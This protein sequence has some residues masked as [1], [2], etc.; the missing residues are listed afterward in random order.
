[1]RMVLSLTAAALCL[2]LPGCALIEQYRAEQEARRLA[3]YQQKVDDHEEVRVACEQPFERPEIAVLRQKIPP[4][5]QQP[6]IVQ[7]ADKTR[8]N[9]RQKAA[10]KALDELLQDCRIKQGWLENRYSSV[11][12]PAHVAGAERS[13]ALLSELWAGKLTFGQYNKGRQEIVALYE[14]ESVELRQQLQIVAAQERAAEAAEATRRA[15]ESAERAAWAERR[16]V[17]K[18]DGRKLRCKDEVVAR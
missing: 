3:A 5:T 13:R 7:M 9:A 17:C 1:M 16:T 6:T 15:A 12:Y 18:R 10:L 8:P 14:R 2:T 11:T 4:L